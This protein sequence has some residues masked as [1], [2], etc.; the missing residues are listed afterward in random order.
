MKICVHRPPCGIDKNN[1]EWLEQLFRQT[2]G[3]G[4]EIR[5]DDFKKI[6]VSKNVSVQS[7]LRQIRSSHT[8]F[9]TSRLRLR[10]VSFLVGCVSQNTGV[11]SQNTGVV[12]RE[13]WKCAARLITA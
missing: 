5:L 9:H 8:A 3:N 12:S 7:L 13:Q 10:G 1:L 2:V 4:K 6:V 11:V